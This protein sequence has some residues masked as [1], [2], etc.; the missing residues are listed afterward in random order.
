[1]GGIIVSPVVPTISRSS[2]RLSALTGCGAADEEG[3]LFLSSCIV[4]SSSL[5][6][7]SAV[8]WDVAAWDAAV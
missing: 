2:Y 3:L 1:V 5:F 4:T 8:A 7:W 6:S